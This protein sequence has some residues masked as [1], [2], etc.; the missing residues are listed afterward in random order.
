MRADG[1]ACGALGS[2]EATFQLRQGGA[3]VNHA[4]A[5]SDAA[6]TSATKAYST[7]NPSIGVLMISTGRSN[8][9]FAYARTRLAST[10]SAVTPLIPTCGSMRGRRL[11]RLKATI[12]W[13]TFKDFSGVTTRRFHETEPSSAVCLIR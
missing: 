6:G 5:R 12:V 8:A 7:N 1:R 4:A 3:L 9:R 11:S 13:I 10:F 2:A